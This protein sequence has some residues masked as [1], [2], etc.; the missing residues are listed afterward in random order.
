MEKYS[1]IKII[2]ATLEDSE[3]HICSFAAMPYE[4][5]LFGYTPNH[6]SYTLHLTDTRLIVEPDVNADFL[7]KFYSL[8]NFIPLKEA[9]YGKSRLKEAI[10]K[11]HFTKYTFISISYQEI[12]RIDSLPAYFNNS[13][14]NI[15]FKADIDN[16]SL[17]FF[18]DLGLE[19][20]KPFPVQEIQFNKIW[21]EINQKG[22]KNI[23]LEFLKRIGEMKNTDSTPDFISQATFLL[24][25]SKFTG[26]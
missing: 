11:M 24:E 21:E 3:T 17:I 18:K 12:E 16:R 15:V 7:E 20:F 13:L 10:K 9:H 19:I 23:S 2:N 25:L 5:S 6:A 4:K 1:P 8:M 26:K 22:L 14:V